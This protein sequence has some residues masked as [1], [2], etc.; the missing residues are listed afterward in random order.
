MMETSNEDLRPVIFG[1]RSDS[2]VATVKAALG[3]ASDYWERIIVSTKSDAIRNMAYDQ[4]HNMNA[5][6]KRIEHEAW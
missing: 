2:D 5:I 4:Q 6:A 1:L 3:I